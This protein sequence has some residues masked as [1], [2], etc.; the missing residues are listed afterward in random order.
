MRRVFSL[1]SIPVLLL[2][3]ACGAG[4][5]ESDS[6]EMKNSS[7]PAITKGAKFGEKP[8]LSSGRGIPP[9]DLKVEV[10]SEGKGPGLK[11]GDIAKVHYLGMA[12]GEKEPFDQN[13]DQGKPLDVTIGA[14]G[15]IKGWEQGLEG[16]KAGSRIELVIPPG[17]GYGKQG[18]GKIKPDATLVFVVDI[19]KATSIPAAVAGKQVPQD[20]ESLPKV[21]IN[22]DGKEVSLSVPK[23]AAPPAVLVSNYVLEGDGPAVKDTDSVV[24]RYVGKTWTND[25]PFQS[26]Y[27]NK[28][29]DT[30]EFGQISV[31]GLKDGIKGKKVGSRI[32]IVIP[33]SLG[34]GDREQGLIPAN[35][36]VVLALDI[37]AAQ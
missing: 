14:G 24:V 34:F 31:K 37:L 9:K 25:K 3:A 4:H 11:K 10:I 36:T 28:T 1:I 12:W 29:P 13:F 2:A 16:K 6:A 20:S 22:I 33:P 23:G 5:Q 32:L 15:V 35:S 7:L 18:V 26:T 8:T 17:M 19:L 27:A 21:G 30:W